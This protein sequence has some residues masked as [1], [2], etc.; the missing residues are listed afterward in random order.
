MNYIEKIGKKDT[1][2]RAGKGKGEV[3]KNCLLNLGSLL[4]L[5]E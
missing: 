3:K 1:K 4:W 2:D 5:F